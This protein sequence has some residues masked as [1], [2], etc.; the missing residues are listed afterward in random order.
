MTYTT[1]TPTFGW[2]RCDEKY[3]FF[4]SNVPNPKYMSILKTLILR[5][6]SSNKFNLE[7]ISSLIPKLNVF[8]KG[9]YESWLERCH[10]R[11]P[12]KR[13]KGA[14][15]LTAQGPHSHILM[16]GGEGSPSNSWGLK[17]WPKWFFWVYERRRD[18][19]VAKTDK[20]EEFSW[21]CEKR[22]K[23]FFWVC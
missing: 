14:A 9:V 13:V 15:R 2:P 7:N 4:E 8:K 20:A 16:T 5:L 23:I 22:T 19:M 11:L 21:G 18:F 10:S 3:M 1:P 6:R 17:F 12:I